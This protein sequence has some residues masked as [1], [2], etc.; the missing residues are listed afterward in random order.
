MAGGWGCGFL[1]SFGLGRNIR[2]VRLRKERPSLRE[3]WAGTRTR[4]IPDSDF[5]MGADPSC[6]MVR[7]QTQ[8]DNGGSGHGDR[9]LWIIE[10][11]LQKA[12]KRS[13]FKQLTITY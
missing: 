6:E 13:L 8:P 5:S 12:G 2:R 4:S 1:G 9:K 7:K 11:Y 3:T 10:N